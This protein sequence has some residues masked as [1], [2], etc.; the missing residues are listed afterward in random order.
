MTP[1][2]FISIGSLQRRLTTGNTETLQFEPGVNVLVGRP[3]TGKTKWLETRDYLLGDPGGS[4]FEGQGEEPLADKY[5]AASVELFIGDER[6]NVE[7]RWKE[8]GAKNKIFVNDAAFAAPDFQ[9]LL[10]EK[11]YIPILHFP[12]GNPM[13]GQTWPELSFRTLLRHMYRRQRFW[14]DIA[15]QQPE[16]DQ[17]ASILQF[18]GLAES[19]FNDDYG[20]L[21]RLKMESERLRARRDQYEQTLKELA[22]DV[23]TD[24]TLQSSITEGSVREAETRLL[25]ELDFL[26]SQRTQVLREARDKSIQPDRRARIEQLAEHRAALIVG[27]EEQRLRQGAVTERRAGITQYRSDLLEESDRLNR[28]QD[29]GEVLADL[30]I[31]HCPACD[32]PVTDS[33]SVDHCFLCH[34]SLPDEPTVEGLGVARLRFE[35]ERLVGEIT[36][37]D[38][39]SVVLERDAKRLADQIRESQ[40]Q[41]LMVENELAPA[42]DAVS[43]LAQDAVS[44]ID[45]ALGELSER[46]RQIGRLK[47]A[48]ELGQE[49]TN[50]VAAIEKDIEPI[51]AR[52]DNAMRAT[53]F[54]E[55]ESRLSDGMNEYVQAINRLRPGAWPHNPI[56]VDVTRWGFR[57]RVGSRQWDKVLGGTDT[58][59]FLM[60]YQYGLLA[61]SDKQDCH[62]PGLSIIDVPGEFS[63]EAVEDKENFIVQPFIDLLA[64]DSFRGAQA[65]ITGAAFTGLQGAN[66]KRLTKIFVA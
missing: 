27:L 19:I 17:H 64:R 16:G 13:S 48:L 30:R 35:R 47:T 8:T 15:D 4:P 29:A 21:I 60:A 45:V 1:S 37:A 39:L 65:I 41:L 61:L 50:K 5:D 6:M 12:K 25:A 57:M 26:R 56:T 14:G 40:E 49:L 62:Y 2:R 31:T 66:L 38:E 28:A 20:E 51:Q 22:G 11:L 32:Q 55:A 46:Q 33:H 7:R 53:D 44:A 59:Y 52:V 42:R 63:G 3:N 10:L 36:E 24:P 23:L 9:R 18:L 58:L 34:Q 43:A 54:G